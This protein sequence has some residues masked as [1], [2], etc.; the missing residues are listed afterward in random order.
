MLY[1][2]FYDALIAI[3]ALIGTVWIVDS[4]RAYGREEVEP[5]AAGAADEL[6]GL[7]H[8]DQ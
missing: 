3:N 7:P 1:N 2:V 4:W 8:R 5:T 6:Q